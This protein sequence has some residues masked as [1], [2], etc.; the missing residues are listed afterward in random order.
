MRNAAFYHRNHA[1]QKLEEKE[2]KIKRRTKAYLV[3]FI[4]DLYAYLATYNFILEWHKSEK[5]C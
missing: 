5:G 1:M 3:L 4:R 2:E